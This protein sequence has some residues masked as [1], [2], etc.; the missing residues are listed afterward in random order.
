MAFQAYC[1][2]S[3][4]SPELGID[5]IDRFYF[6]NILFLFEEC[7]G[8]SRESVVNIYSQLNIQMQLEEWLR[9]WWPIAI[10]TQMLS[11][12]EPNLWAG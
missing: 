2:Y 3:N 12:T 7:Y 10:E 4:G 1:K 9:V 6:E 5:G 11:W 8:V